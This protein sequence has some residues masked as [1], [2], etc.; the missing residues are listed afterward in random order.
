MANCCGGSSAV[1]IHG[2]GD[3]AVSGSG[4]V[5]DPYIVSGDLD[6]NLAA[7]QTPTIQMQIAGSGTFDDPYVFTANLIAGLGDL[8][9]VAVITTPTTGYVL[10][11][12]GSAWVAAAAPTQPP[13]AVHVGPGIEG[14]GTVVTPISINVSNVVDT[15]TAGLYTYIDSAGE[16]RAQLPSSSSVAWTSITGKPT[17]FTPS[18]HTHLNADL[19][20]MLSGTSAPGSGVGSDGAWF[21][22]YV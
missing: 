7:A 13:G 1:V 18:P 8:S 14:D 5:G 21:A 20:Q 12:D 19:T 4:T 15:S 22:Q 3:V 2:T 6:V 10:M 16:L 11:W 17:T 9:D